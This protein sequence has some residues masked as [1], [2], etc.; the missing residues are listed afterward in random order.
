MISPDW[1][2][3]IAFL[4]FKYLNICLG[5]RHPKK[6]SCIQS[7][8]IVYLSSIIFVPWTPAHMDYKYDIPLATFLHK[9]KKH[10]SGLLN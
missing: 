6:M 7:L 5:A 4:I 2:T 1:Y 10:K 3:S 8:W 9:N